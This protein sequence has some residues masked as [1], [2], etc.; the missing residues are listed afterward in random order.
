MK[1]SPLAV[2]V[3]LLVSLN[4]YAGNYIVQFN[5]NGPGEGGMR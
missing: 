1:S 4:A 2:V 5:G 3:C